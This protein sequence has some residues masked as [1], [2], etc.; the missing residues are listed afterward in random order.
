MAR[1]FQVLSNG[2]WEY[3]FSEDLEAPPS[4]EVVIRQRFLGEYPHEHGPVKAMSRSKA[5]GVAKNLITQG[6]VPI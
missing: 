6:Y 5:H 3:E 2:K 4:E 1:I